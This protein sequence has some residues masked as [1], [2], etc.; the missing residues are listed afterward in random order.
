MTWHVTKNAYDYE[1]MNNAGPQWGIPAKKKQLNID[2]VQGNFNTN[3]QG[4]VQE[5][6]LYFKHQIM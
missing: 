1:D 6:S 3:L 4:V 5:Y 2:L